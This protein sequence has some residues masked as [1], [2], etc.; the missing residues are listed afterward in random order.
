M[1]MLLSQ[2][3][4]GSLDKRRNAQTEPRTRDKNGTIRTSYYM[5]KRNW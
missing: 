2:T 3:Q 5:G 4:H 1:L